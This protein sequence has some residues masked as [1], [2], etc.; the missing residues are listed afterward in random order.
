MK[1]IKVSDFLHVVKPEYKFI[2]I[3]PNN[4]IR[5][6]ETHK[7][8]RTIASLY[9]QLN[10]QLRKDEAK[11]VK[12]LGREF[13]VGTKYSFEQPTKVSYYIYIEKKKAEFYFV[14]P[15]KYYS[16]I[17][18]KLT[19][20]WSNLTVE[21][22]A[23]LPAFSESA[24]KHQLVYMKED[25]LSLATNRANNDLLHST[26]NIIDVMEEGDRVAVFYNFIPTN[27]NAFKA[28]YRNTIDRVKKGL[29]VDRNKLGLSYAIKLA[30]GTLFYIADSISE[31]LGEMGGKKKPK[32]DSMFE[33]L[34]EQMNGAKKF[35]DSTRK[36][37]SATILDTQILVMSES[38]D[39]LRERNNAKSLAQ[40]F[41]SIKVSSRRLTTA[42][43]GRRLTKSAMRR[44]RTFYRCQ[45]GPCS[46]ATILSIR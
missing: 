29:P 40:A 44:R 11:A 30:L 42:S 16:V 22:V 24:T 36:K 15:C 28:R 17:K 45:G 1:R 21:E 14:V 12:V 6:N 38:A 37:A 10:E 46:K 13:L 31:A 39:K 8:A 25:G 18:E 7:L 43:K 19:D 32:K 9:K 20:V 5:N 27:Q 2:R 34:L 23:E 35:E 3:K 41:D 4:S 26:L 33:A